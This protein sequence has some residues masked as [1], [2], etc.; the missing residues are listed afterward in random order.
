M[1]LLLCAVI[2]VGG[3]KVVKDLRPSPLESRMGEGEEVLVSGQVCWK[4]E[5]DDYQ[6]IYLKDNSVISTKSERS[7]KESRLILYDNT[8]EEA[9]IGQLI[10]ARGQLSFFEHARNPGNFDQKDYYRRQG[11]YGR[12]W[13]NEVKAADGKKNVLLDKLQE[14][15]GAWQHVFQKHMETEDS[16]I[17]AAVLL[18]NKGEMDVDVKELYQTG[19]IGHILA[20]S[21][22]HLSLIGLGMYRLLR[23]A[24]GSFAA[25]GAAGILF[26]IL[27]ICMI[28]LTVSAVRALVMFL[29]RVG[30]DLAGRK[31]DS[32]TALSVAAVTGL[33]WRPLSIYDGGFWL[34]FGAVAA[35]LVILPVFGTL[36][37]YDKYPFL[38]G[39][40]G[41]ISVSLALTPVLL[42][43]FYEI[44]LYSSIL[45]FFVLPLMSPL[46]VS[47]ILGGL[48][49]ILS[50]CTGVPGFVQIF[51]ET[52]GGLLL[53]VCSWILSFFEKCC[54]ISLNLP[55]ARIVTGRPEMWQMVV[56]YALL[57]TGLMLLRHKKSVWKL[58]AL[59][60][61][62]AGFFLI[63]FPSVDQG[64][65]K[66]CFV[67]VGQGDCIFIQGEKG[68]TYLVDGGSNDIKGVG[69]YR[70]EPFLLSQGVGKLDYVFVSHGDADHINGIEELLER[71]EVGIE[72]GTLVLPVREVWEEHLER[73]AEKAR[74]AGIRV[75]EMKP[76]DHVGADRLR[77]ICIQPGENS[78]EEPG[79]SA[80][81]VLAVNYGNFDM[82]LTGDVEGQGEDELTEHIREDYGKTRWEVLKTAHHGSRNSTKE[83]FLETV[84]P[85]CA[86]ISA[87]V[88]NS[89]GHPH[90]ETLERLQEAEVN[91]YSTAVSGMVMIETDGEKLK[92]SGF[93][94]KT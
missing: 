44:P 51:L 47:G 37:V 2:H 5:K 53:K 83:E 30:A 45:N 21:G 59:L 52:G 64:E 71:Q 19:G 49:L 23:R 27:Y 78:E 20:I 56:Y 42:Y 12:V 11:I 28:G 88:D 18:G 84:S 35:L 4:E 65:C 15:R 26:L 10:Y 3:G 87:G 58:C 43:Y 50:A 92:L 1:F 40:W 91:M 75:A 24:T 73:L 39:I 82:L 38:R 36:S 22:L 46:L 90:R 13:A 77:L 33:L 86:V 54:D 14:I 9:A 80:S 66:V 48:L 89:Y 29:F 94:H 76:G 81:M 68:E 16:G 74:H 31:Y 79:N 34:S 62:A 60:P 57:V 67:D 41:S 93:C 85:A 25:G 61:L 6:I 17:L 8:K 32:P 72:I 70:I 69:Q 7:V 63:A 55:G